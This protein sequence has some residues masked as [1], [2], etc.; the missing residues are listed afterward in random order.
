MI[1][2]MNSMFLTIKVI[3]YI[4]EYDFFY[5][6]AQTFQ[7]SFPW[8]MIFSLILGLQMLGFAFLFHVEFGG[9]IAEFGSPIVSLVTLFKF[10]LGDFEPLLVRMLTR[11]FSLTFISFILFMSFFYFV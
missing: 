3:K 8:F 7:K 6:T 4:R 1:G 5:V 2:A 9:F 10:L 11:S